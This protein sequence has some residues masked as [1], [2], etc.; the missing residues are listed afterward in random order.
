MII[1]IYK[2]GINMSIVSHSPLDLHETFISKIQGHRARNQKFDV[3]K[4]FIFLLY[5]GWH[6]KW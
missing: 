1:T 3:E 6:L 4:S 2:H 5:V